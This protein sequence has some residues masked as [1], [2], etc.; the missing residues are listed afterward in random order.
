MRTTFPANPIAAFVAIALFAP[1]LWMAL[2]R[3]PPYVITNG[4]ITPP[5]PVKNG[6]VSIDWDIAPLRSCQPGNHSSVV[7]TVID[8]MGVR[9]VYAPIAATYGTA[10]QFK[11]EEIRRSFRLPLN[12][13]GKVSYSA[14]VCYSCNP[15]QV[16]WPVCLDTPTIEFFI[17]DE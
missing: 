9:H 16:L 17:A 11:P 15:I 4:R 8:A 1:L 2:D 5:M 10:E 6:T 12:I 3:D 13:T 7:R 14:K